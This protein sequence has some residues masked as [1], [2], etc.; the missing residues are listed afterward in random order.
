MDVGVKKGIIWLLVILALLGTAALAESDGY[1]LEN[2]TWDTSDEYI[3][4]VLTAVWQGGCEGDLCLTMYANGNRMDPQ[5]GYVIMDGAETY[6]YPDL[7]KYDDDGNEI[8]YTVKERYFDGY[9][10]MY[11]NKRPHY[12][13]TKKIY[14]NGVIINRLIGYE[15]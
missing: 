4:F 11:V 6:I 12:S 15:G 5:P 9:T 10:A 7:P 8:V 13:E 2:E 1:E 3:D 14:N